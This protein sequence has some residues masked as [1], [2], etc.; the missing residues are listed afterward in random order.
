LE[1][2]PSMRECILK[3]EDKRLSFWYF[4]NEK[5]DL[6][7][8]TEYNLCGDVKKEF[9]DDEVKKYNSR[10]KLGGKNH[11]FEFRVKY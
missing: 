9:S 5:G 10:Y 11:D 6:F 8:I 1:Q 3:P 4:F 2:D 7:K